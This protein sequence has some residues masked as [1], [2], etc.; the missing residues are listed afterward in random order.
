MQIGQQV[1]LHKAMRHLEPG[2]KLA[3]IIQVTG[4]QKKFKKSEQI[5]ST[6][7]PGLIAYIYTG[8]VKRY[9]I[10]SAGNV[11]I[12]AV[13]GPKEILPL[14]VIFKTILGEEIYKGP[15]PYFYEAMTDCSAS[16][17]SPSELRAIIAN[18]SSLYR[19]LFF[20]SARRLY[21]NIQH[22]EN[23][24]LSSADKRIAH[25]ITFFAREYAQKTSKGLVINLPLTQQDIADILSITRETASIGFNKL[26]NQNLIRVKKDLIVPDLKKLEEFA[27][28]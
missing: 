6:E 15:E 8:F 26:K 7:V 13:Y 18:D 4:R 5:Y 12:Q 25:Q 22:L 2:Q 28:S 3:N 1:W 11:R 10:S 19:D 14:T 20:V 24:S 21:S 16:I 23:M 9:L 27:F 17:I